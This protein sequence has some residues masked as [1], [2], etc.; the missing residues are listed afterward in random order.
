MQPGLFA[1]L[2]RGDGRVPS[3]AVAAMGERCCARRCERRT[4]RHGLPALREASV[5]CHRALQPTDAC[6][7]VTDALPAG[8]RAM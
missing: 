8:R 3:A 4:V 5:S 7:V 6:T 1:L 2:P